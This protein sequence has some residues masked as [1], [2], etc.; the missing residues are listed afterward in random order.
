M[1]Q[2]VAQEKPLY[3]DRYLVLFLQTLIEDTR[4]EAVFYRKTKLA[5]Y[6]QSVGVPRAWACEIGVASPAL[7]LPS[8]I[9]VRSIYRNW[10]SIWP[11]YNSSP[12]IEGN[13]LSHL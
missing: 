1:I 10:T 7:H 6:H 3:V 11:M 8:K 13:E 4:K 9:E 2:P 12:A 5:A